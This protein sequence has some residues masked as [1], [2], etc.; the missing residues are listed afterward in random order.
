MA[1]KIKFE[2][3]TPTQLLRSEEA[4]MVVVPI[5]CASWNR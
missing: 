4:D 1:E 5:V 2:V 3:V